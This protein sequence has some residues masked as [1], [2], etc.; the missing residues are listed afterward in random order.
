MGAL[1]AYDVIADGRRLELELMEGPAAARTPSGR[2][3]LEWAPTSEDLGEHRFLIRLRDASGLTAEQ[4]FAVTVE[5]EPTFSDGTPPA[6]D[7]TRPFDFEAA[8]GFLYQG[9]NARQQGVRPGAISGERLSVLH[10]VVRDRDGEALPMVR[11]SAK[12]RPELGHTHTD[13]DGRFAFAINGGGSTMLRFE[14]PGFLLSERSAVTG[15]HQHGSLL[16]VALVPLSFVVTQV[17][18]GAS[19]LQ[20]ARGPVEEDEDGPRQ[21]TLLLPP[22]TRATLVTADGKRTAATSLSLRATEYTVGTHGAKAMP[23]PLPATS[24]YTYA[25]EISADEAMDLGATSVEF[26]RPVPFYVE[27]FLGFPVGEKVPAGYYD[28]EDSKWK[29]ERDG[30]VIAVLSHEGGRARIDLDGDG[31]AEPESALLEYGFGAEELSRL[32]SLY[33]AG[34]T[35]WRVELPHLTA[36]DCN[37]PFGPPPEAVQPPPNL[38]RPGPPEREESEDDPCEKEGSIIECDDGG[39]G[40]SMPLPG[41]GYSLHYRSRRMPGWRVGRQ[42]HIPILGPEVPAGVE[43]VVVE[44]EIAG[45]TFREELTPAPNLSHDFE[46]DGLDV[47]GRE[48]YGELELK[49]RVGN[50]YRPIFYRGMSLSPR[51][52]GLTSQDISI[53]GASRVSVN[54]TDARAI[55]W[56]ALPKTILKARRPVSGEIGG[57]TIDVSHRLTEKGIELGDGRARRPWLHGQVEVAAGS[58]DAESPISFEHGVRRASAISN[59]DIYAFVCDRELGRP[60]VL[61]L[62]RVFADRPHELVLEPGSLTL[63]TGEVIDVQHTLCS[64]SSAPAEDRE[65]RLVFAY[66]GRLLRYDPTSRGFEWLAGNGEEQTYRNVDFATLTATSAA[67][68]DQPQ[69]AVGPAGEILISGSRV[70]YELRDRSLQPHAGFFVPCTVL[71]GEERTRCTADARTGFDQRLALRADFRGIRGMAFGPDGTLYVADHGNQN[72]QV[73]AIGPDGIVRRIAGRSWDGAPR[74]R[75]WSA[76]YEPTPATELDLV[77]LE[78]IAVGQDGRIFLTHT[79]SHPDGGWGTSLLT[80]FFPGAVLDW[81]GGAYVWDPGLRLTEAEH[82][83]VDL[84][85]RSVIRASNHGEVMSIDPRGQLIFS[86]GRG[87]RALLRMRPAAPLRGGLREIADPNG[88]A[89]L[90]F[91]PYSRLVE[92]R[93]RFDG[94]VVRR[95]EHDDAGRLVGIIEADGPEHTRIERDEHGHPVAVIGPYGHRSELTV[96]ANGLLTE[97]RDPLGRSFR[98]EYQGASGLLTAFIDP[99]G[100]RSEYEYQ[101]DGRLRVA[102]AADGKTQHLTFEQTAEGFAVTHRSGAGRITRYDTL[103]SRHGSTGRRVTTGTGRSRSAD[104]G[105]SGSRSLIAS[106]G[107]RVSVRLSPAAPRDQAGPTVEQLHMT[108]PSGA[109]TQ[110]SHTRELSRAEGEDP[111]APPSTFVHRITT[112]AGTA[113]IRYDAATRSLGTESPAGRRST[114]R[115]DAEGRLVETEQAGLLSLRYTHDGRGRLVSTTQGDRITRYEYDASGNVSAV[116]DPAGRRHV[117]TYDEAERII[118]DT[119]PGGEVTRYAYDLNDNLA[120]LVPPSRPAH[121][122]ERDERARTLSHRTPE[123]PDAPGLTRTEL[124]GENRA[125][126]TVLASGETVDITRDEA[127]RP[128]RVDSP[129][130]AFTYAYDPDSGRLVSSTAPNGL[131]THRIY[132]GPLPLAETTTGEVSSVVRFTHEADSFRLSSETVEGTAPIELGFDGDGMPTVVGP[133]SLSY[134]LDG[135]PDGETLGNVTSSQSHDGY[136]G[137]VR[138]ET[139]AGSS[140]VLETVLAYDVLGRIVEESN[141]GALGRRERRVFYNTNGQIDRVLDDGAEIERYTYDDNGNRLSAA[142]RGEFHAAQYDVRDRVSSYGPWTYQYDALGRLA[143]RVRSEDG[144]AEGYD[145]DSRGNLLSVHL[146]DGRE[147]SYAA[148]AAGR[149]VL[150]RMNGALTHGYVYS[151]SRLVAELGPGGSVRSHFIYGHT[152]HV[153]AGMWRAG[154]WYAFVT[155]ARGSVRAVVDSTTA[156]VAQA[157]DY[158]AFG[159]VLTDSNPGFQPF[160][161]AG[162]LYDS[163]TGLVRFGA[164][165]YDPTLG[166][167]TAPDPLGFAAGDTSLY[168]YAFSDPVNLIDPSGEIAFCPLF[169]GALWGYKIASALMTLMELLEMSQ[170]FMDPCTSDERRMEMLAEALAGMLADLALGKLGEK[171]GKHLLG[172]L[173]QKFGIKACFIAGTLVATPGGAQAIDALASGD[174]VLAVDEHTGVVS[175]R[176]VLSVSSREV[177]RYLDLRLESPEADLASHLGVTAEHPFWTSTGW[178]KAGELVPGDRAIASKPA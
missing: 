36:W 92:V 87:N 110:L 132:D 139:Y 118:T 33:T 12:A 27:N 52:F 176:P 162:G 65:G 79:P 53:E 25:V 158:D 88:T 170:E 72:G 143:S 54:L 73:R 126:R 98:A 74:S 155:D 32:A 75:F 41:T 168:V 113:Q 140:L 97:L 81:V 20:V 152:R 61:R 133:L 164:R 117:Y 96:D 4:D 149:R 6:L 46:W 130:G 119:R 153:P 161:F 1:Y 100:H 7:P 156:V 39:L 166:R 91:D 94:R 163:E 42:V 58:V 43:K 18:L 102:R 59:G 11:I 35:L 70:I 105:T 137:L 172:W 127:G 165:D 84:D 103:L 48:V 71:T 150:R 76:D 151:G 77:S 111:S 51:S 68:P 50:A 90:V 45:R 173:A 24:G 120:E 86:A 174:V 145:Y 66:G 114:S 108:L 159:V 22:N 9:D 178:T 106:D 169:M 144:T 10:G 141:T 101:A 136:G 107:T 146:P 116:I 5:A 30:L 95:F 13:T 8:Y 63:A 17:S 148:D 135:R 49:G 175:E 31:E 47:F 55:M 167:W 16:Q 80:S 14:K 60:Y 23:S 34:T 112:A 104:R 28:F 64:E 142:V 85:P 21:A 128:V 44:L 56:R 40:Q 93:S 109:Q 78:G 115:Y 29:A 122:F 37:W 3:R 177:E 147:V 138:S 82:F 15:W 125:Q 160:G 69:V 157:L 154:V 57:F 129:E 89:I 121:R 83:G 2:L 134:D 131:G 38:P 67:L 26:D 99:K 19:A 62:F 171:F 123:L 124:D